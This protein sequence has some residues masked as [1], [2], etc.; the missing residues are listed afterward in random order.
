MIVGND[1]ST[2]INNGKNNFISGFG[3]IDNAQIV[4]LNPNESRTVK[5]NGIDYNI[6]NQYSCVQ[7]LAY[8]VNPV[9]E[10][11]SF[12]GNRYLKIEGQQ[13]VS[14]NVALYGWCNFYGGEKDDV[15]TQY[16]W[17]QHIYGQGGNDK[18][19]INGNGTA[20]GG[21]GDDEIIL[22]SGGAAYGDDGDDT[23]TVN[24]SN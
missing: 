21:A 16:G 1:S 5:I 7:V 3:D 23:I 17:S 11:I 10:E 4:M 12:C 2:L 24:A 19:T 14:H 9:T 8:S 6:T 15:I 18:I 22:N 13:D 20:H